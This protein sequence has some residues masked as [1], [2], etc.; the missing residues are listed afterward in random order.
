[1]Y[2]LTRDEHA[3][4]LKSQFDRAITELEDVARRELNQLDENQ[5]LEKL[6]GE[7]LQTEESRKRLD[8][9]EQAEAENLNRIGE[10]TERMEKLMQDAARNGEIDEETLRKM[11]ESLKS[12][13]ELSSKD[14]PK[15]RK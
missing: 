12:L 6:K 9:Q 2:V 1:I 10:L 5:R 15:V 13:Q 7:E 4:M 8:I 11:A 14:M 3:Q